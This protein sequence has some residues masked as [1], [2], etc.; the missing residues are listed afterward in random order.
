MRKGR[1]TEAWMQ[2]ERIAVLRAACGYALEHSLRY[3]TMEDG[4][5]AESPASGH[6]DYGAQWAYCG[7]RYIGRDEELPLPLAS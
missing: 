7:C 6:V 5:K 3:P 1:T 4:M 2:A